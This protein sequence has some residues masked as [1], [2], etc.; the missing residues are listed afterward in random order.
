[1]RGN[2]TVAISAGSLAVLLGALDTYVVVTLFRD[3]MAGVGIDGYDD[4]QRITP[5]VTW[6]LLGYIAAMPLLGRASDRFGRKL[7]IQ[8]SLAAF[9]VG[10]VVTAMSDDVP[11]I[12]VGRVIQGVASGALLPVTLALA[13]CGPPASGPRCWVV[14]ARRRSLAACSDRC[15]ASSSSGCCGTGATCSGS[16]CHWRRSRW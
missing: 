13:T 6:Y 10:S 4:I 15:T 11:M 9:A 3:I 5:I 12:V 8:G 2:R 14:S 7:L 16:T 1:M